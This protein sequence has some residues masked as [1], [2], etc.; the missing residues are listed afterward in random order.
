MF[1]DKLF[2]LLGNKDYKN[3]PKQIFDKNVVNFLDEL[4]K[5]ILKNKRNND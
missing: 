3:F 1:K 4:S 5:T 2:I